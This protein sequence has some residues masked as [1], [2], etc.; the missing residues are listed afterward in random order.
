MPKGTD[1]N[2]WAQ[3]AEMLS[4]KKETTLKKRTTVNQFIRNPYTNNL[5]LETNTDS[6]R[7]TYIDVVTQGSSSD[8]DM[9]KQIKADS[10]GKKKVELEKEAK[11]TFDWDM[12]VVLIRKYFHDYWRRIMDKFKNQ[13]DLCENINKSV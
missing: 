3:F 7:W 6:P 4:V 9:S 10:K 5:N 2:K 8:F 12:T 1:K 13:L 11:E